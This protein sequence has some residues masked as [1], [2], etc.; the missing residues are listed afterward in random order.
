MPLVEPVEHHSS[1]ELSDI[2]EDTANITVLPESSSYLYV[3]G[4]LSR[5]LLPQ[6]P[7][8]TAKMRIYCLHPECTKKWTVSRKMTTTSNYR[9]HYNRKHPEV[10]L[11]EAKRLADAARAQDGGAALL[12][13]TKENW[14][15]RGKHGIL[16][17]R[18]K[19]LITE[20]IVKCGLSLRT[21]E[22][23]AFRR[24]QEFLDPAAPIFSR[25]TITREL[26]IMF[27]KGR[28]RLHQ[29]LEAQVLSGG[30][31]SLTLDIWSSC[32]RQDYMGITAHF[33][34]KDLQLE[35]GLLDFVPM[36]EGHTGR[37]QCTVLVEV[38]MEYNLLHRVLSITTDNA[39]CNDKL[40]RLLSTHQMKTPASPLSDGQNPVLPVNFT[41]EN[42]H[43]RCMAHILNL[44]CQ[45][46]LK[47]LNSE[48]STVTEDYLFNEGDP[49]RPGVRVTP[50]ASLT[51]YAAAMTKTRRIIAKFRNSSKLRKALSQVIDW[52]FS[53]LSSWTLILDCPTRWSSTADMLHVF[54]SLWPAVKTVME[55]ASPSYKFSPLM[56]GAYEVEELEEL[57]NVFRI[58][59]VATLQISGQ[60]Y[61][62]ISWV[63]PFFVQV[64]TQLEE[65]AQEHGEDTEL[66]EACSAAW[67]KMSHYYTDSDTKSYLATATI[68]DPRYRFGV[69]DNLEWTFAEKENAF[70]CFTQQFRLYQARYVEEIAASTA[71][72]IEGDAQSQQHPRPTDTGKGAAPK[73]R[74]LAHP[75]D[76]I[77]LLSTGLF[78]VEEEDAA[79]DAE[80]AAYQDERRLKAD[81]NPLDFWRFNSS[82]YPVLSRMVGSTST[83]FVFFFADCCPRFRPGISCKSRPQVCRQRQSFRSL[84]R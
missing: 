82:R 36:A 56:L 21:V 5:E 31:I 35:S 42:G 22:S 67:R 69:F 18:L 28:E 74:K 15:K 49:L 80:I 19:E 77:A 60:T 39:S 17:Q 37:E 64:M 23:P 24:Y 59:K 16:R 44:A 33:L 12:A 62:T 6:E 55:G 79:P 2:E 11:S 40:M 20:L 81:A 47:S 72:S 26:R 52:K 48:G 29:R 83:T 71:A 58:F 34:T 75:D 30:F 8:K 43:V 7:N 14:S 84:R 4:L 70:E 51:G 53:Q 61:P 46:V 1:S 3:A 73:R 78:Y 57:L 54:I 25:Q 9:R 50:L 76:D 41:P 63:L 66:G 32:V 13:H 10:A 68:L 27:L 45:S 65:R 38:L